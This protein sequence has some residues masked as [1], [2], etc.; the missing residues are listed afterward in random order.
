[1][2]TPSSLEFD[3]DKSLSSVPTE[4]LNVMLL[5]ADEMQACIDAL[6]RG[7]LNLVGEALRGE[8]EFIELEHYPHD[9]VYDAASQSQYY[10]HAHRGLVGEHGHFHTYIRQ[11]GTLRRMQPAESPGAHEWPAGDD[12]LAHL[13][14][15]S[16]DSYGLPLGLFTTNRWVAGDTWYAASDLI[17]LLGNFGIDHAAPSWPLNRWLTGLFTLFRPQMTALLQS[18]DVTVARWQQESPDTDVLEDR[19]RD[20]ASWMPIDP[21]EQRKAVAQAAA[22]RYGGNK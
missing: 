22:A 20:I 9:D 12:A 4:T 15:V 17:P 5:A 1:M 16:M 10:Y 8:G 18:R 19:S 11:P 2:R 14:A 21:I 7:G 13:V 6:D 3:L